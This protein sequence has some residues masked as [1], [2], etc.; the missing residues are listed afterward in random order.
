MGLLGIGVY[1][2]C[3]LCGS[4]SEFF[5]GV[6]IIFILFIGDLGSF[7]VFTDFTEEESFGSL[8]EVIFG[9]RERGWGCWARGAGER[10]SKIF[11]PEFSEI[12]YR[13]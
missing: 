11:L 6:L 2:Y 1:I 9:A 5:S 4:D 12:E 13:A 7:R 10:L 3:R 8:E